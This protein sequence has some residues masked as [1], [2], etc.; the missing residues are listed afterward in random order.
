MALEQKGLASFAGR[1]EAL[2]AQLAHKPNEGQDK[3][4]KRTLPILA[5]IKK[6]EKL[7][8]FSSYQKFQEA[9]AQG[10]EKRLVDWLHKN[11]I[12]Y[13]TQVTFD[14][15]RKPL[16]DNSYL[17]TFEA[18]TSY[19]ATEGKWMIDNPPLQENGK[20]YVRNIYFTIGA[21]S[22]TGRKRFVPNEGD[23]TW[24][25]VKSS[26]E[27]TV[28]HALYVKIRDGNEFWVNVR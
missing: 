24:Q 19:I 26:A 18:R 8:A 27:G 20:P 22:E 9:W 15:K 1:Y 21:D 6:L 25:A 14:I 12:D 10:R 2:K 13:T 23:Q 5:A 17:F 4:I 16:L 28:D 7:P 3:Y 11:H